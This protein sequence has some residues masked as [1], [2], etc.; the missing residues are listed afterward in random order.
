MQMRLTQ[1]FKQLSTESSPLTTGTHDIKTS[2][3]TS[4]TKN[5]QPLLQTT[6]N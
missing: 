1:L 3:P 2:L 5:L 4:Q 6:R